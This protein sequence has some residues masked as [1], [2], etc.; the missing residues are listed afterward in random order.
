MEIALL[1]I[2]Y[3]IIYKPYRKIQDILRRTI[4]GFTIFD[5]YNL[6][7]NFSQELDAVF[8]II[9]DTINTKEMIDT[10][11]KQA[12]YLAL[13]NQIN[14]HFLY[15]TLESIRSEAI[16][17]GLDS[18]ADI[19]EALATFYRYTISKVDQ[20]VTIGE[21]L[22]HIKDYISIQRFRFEDKISLEIVGNGQN[23]E[24]YYIPKLILQ[25][26][27]ENAVF[28]GI[29]KK[30]GPG[31]LI[32]RFIV[33]EDRI[34]IVVSDDGVG[35]SYVNLVGLKDKLNQKSLNYLSNDNTSKGGIA[36]IN[37]K[38]R[39]ELLFGEEYGL[40]IYSTPS[41]GTD[42]EIFIPRLDEA[43]YETGTY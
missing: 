37:V 17:E 33:T 38:S 28:H 19:T 5:I 16:I 18:V 43:E 22:K 20:F 14:P 26:I 32:L 31:K 36:L 34:K 30:L 1:V 10:T 15:N 27:V 7:Y 39:I 9:K 42:V 13:Q 2:A 4:N 6:P 11:K 21:E 25:P 3:Q 29:E 35:M 12:E 24:S 41:V 23:V 8:Q 40:T